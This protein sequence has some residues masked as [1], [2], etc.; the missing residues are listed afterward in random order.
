MS[1]LKNN[2]DEVRRKF[3]YKGQDTPAASSSNLSA[4]MSSKFKPVGSKSTP[5]GRPST[6][7]SLPTFS[8]PGFGKSVAKPLRSIPKQNTVEI[9]DISDSS[10]LGKSSASSTSIS[11][12]VVAISSGSSSKRSSPSAPRSEDS[13][14]FK[15][16]PTLNKENAQP[17]VK[18]RETGKF[19]PSVRT[20]DSK[21]SRKPQVKEKE[22]A[23]RAS[24]NPFDVIDDDYP[25]YALDKIEV[26]TPVSKKIFKYPDLL[27]KSPNSLKATLAYN[28]R[29]ERDNRRQIEEYHNGNKPKDI[30]IFMLQS[31]RDLLAE[32]IQALKELSVPE[33]DVPV[34]RSASFSLPIESSYF[35]KPAPEASSSSL[36]SRRCVTP[37]EIEIDEG[38]GEVEVDEMHVSDVDYWEGMDGVEDHI[39]SFDGHQ[40]ALVL[41]P[42]VETLPPAPV[43]AHISTSPFYPEICQN[44]KA[45]FK[46]PGF[47]TNQLEAIYETLAGRDVFVLMPTG[48]GKSLCYQLPAVCRS[49]STRGT[50]I[51]VSPLLALMQNQVASL[52]EK[53]VDVLLWNSETADVGE[54]MRRLRG[55]PKPSLMYVT[56][57]KLKE[58]RQLHSMLAELYQC[59]ELARF[60]IDEAHCISTWGKDF[61]DAYQALG[62]LRDK[63]PNVPIMALTATANKMTVDDIKNRLQLKDCVS[64]TQSF[65]RA[66]LNYYIYPKKNAM[67]EMVKFINQNHRNKT[68]V[69]YCLSRDKCEAVAKQLRDKGFSAKHFHARLE[70]SDKEKVQ[71]EWQSGQVHIIVATIA[72]GMGIDKADVRFVIHHDL[73]KSLDGYYQ[74]T[75]R[76]GR[77]GLPADCVLYYSYRDFESLRRMIRKEKETPMESIERQEQDVRNVVAYCENDSECRRVQLL[78]FFGEKFDKRGCQGRC[79]NCKNQKEKVEYDVSKEARDVIALIKSL[80]NQNVTVDQCRLVLK[81]SKNSQIM[82]K[83]YDKL[84]LYGSASNLSIDI[85]EQLFSKLLFMDVLSEESIA[86]ASGWHTQYLKLG[87]NAERFTRDKQILKISHRP[88]PAKPA[89]TKVRRKSAK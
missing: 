51:V 47:R 66:N 73:P 46:L 62:T 70:T 77:D 15:P 81:G 8:T 57:E 9:I 69:I 52:R 42:A 82:N 53:R 16:E 4:S 72:F 32:R 59:Q 13:K 31:M 37:D 48:G 39:N 5:A 44:L 35:S 30:D 24:F 78:Q 61:R 20:E 33:S 21:V 55:T 27:A 88:K 43:P 7:S 45:V 34:S 84:S 38:E 71:L 54:I 58:S 65:N 6:P 76:A 41:V 89:T 29:L 56:P 23:P 25:E 22:P 49:G 17:S 12:A 28:R 63:Y 86:N 10:P 75:G 19:K 87:T 50:T 83:G 60:V 36:S 18:S 79:D 3:S 1:G 74:E 26:R 14:R 64:F 11:S 67:D 85:I 68:G 40:A 2:L 80:G